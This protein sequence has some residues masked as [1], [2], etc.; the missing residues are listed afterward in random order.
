MKVK[1]VLFTLLAL[2]FVHRLAAQEDNRPLITIGNNVV[3]MGE[4]ERIYHKNNAVTEASSPM[5]VANYLELYINFKLKVIEAES[6]GLDTLP[7]FRNELDGY[8]SQLA[9]P[10]LTDKEFTEKLLKE[11][12]ERA[13]LDVDA[14]HILL[15]LPPTAS[16]ADTLHV[17]QKIMD[18]RKRIVQGE[19]FATI[20]REVSEDP[21]AQQN[22]GDLGYFT[23]FSTVY[24]F[25]NAAYLTPV[26][27]VSMPVRTE[28]GY[29]LVKVNHRQ[30]D[31]GQI[32]VAHIMIICRPESTPEE[33][34][35]AEARINSI[36]ERL[37]QGE[38]F[39]TLA[40]Q[41]SDDRASGRNGGQLDWFGTGRMVSEFENAA[42]ALANNGDISA[43]VRT[44]YGFHII[45]RLDYK[46]LGTYEEIK[47]ELERKLLRDPRVSLGQ[48]SFVSKLKKEYA[49]KEY[50][51]RLEKFNKV[52]DS[53]L[54][55]GQWQVSKADKLTKELFRFAG[56]RRTQQDFARVLNS[57]SWIPS[58][59][60]PE[61]IRKAFKAYSDK[62]LMEYEKAHLEQKYPEFRYLIQEYHD[63]ILLFN[64]TD[65]IVWSKAVNDTTGLMNFY[66]KNK[67]SYAGDTLAEVIIYTLEPGNDYKKIYSK[68]QDA[69]AREEEPSWNRGELQFVENKRVRKNEDPVIQQLPSRPGLYTMGNGQRVIQIKS[70]LPPQPKKLDEI[71]GQVTADYQNELDRQWIA[72]LREKYPVHVDQELLKLIQ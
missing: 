1:A 5:P 28:F 3:T 26:G 9:A 70:I 69:V 27:Q 2:G 21:S 51:K 14:S 6:L 61:F 37:K 65:K 63:G 12:Y 18:I 67:S 22:G 57:Y 16:P 54:F 68:I 33:Q 59:Q 44:A 19:D 24:P 71:R 50:P 64:L 58:R 29:H 40:V 13:K 39:P 15:R 55:T 47:D 43:P 35:D 41:Y 52:A 32:L 25:E 34:A 66:E 45:K 17:Y 53:T 72:S 46:P 31:R 23:V 49:Y 36:Y 4:F 8:R 56:Q 30:P 7:S 62:E 10:Y 48:E 20:A 42:F 60:I 38:D 11:A